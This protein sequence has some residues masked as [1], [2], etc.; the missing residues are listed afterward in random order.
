MSRAVWERNGK[1]LVGGMFQR[2]GW[3]DLWMENLGVHGVCGVRGEAA[4]SG[5]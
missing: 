5:R 3:K 4:N 1:S 2:V